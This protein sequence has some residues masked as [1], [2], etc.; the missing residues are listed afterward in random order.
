LT[1]GTEILEHSFLVNSNLF[2]YVILGDDFFGNERRN[3]SQRAEDFQFIKRNVQVPLW[4]KGPPHILAVTPY[5]ITISPNS[6]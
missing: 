1:I 4:T 5:D 3:N 6:Q 2:V